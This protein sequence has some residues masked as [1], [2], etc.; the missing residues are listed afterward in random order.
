MLRSDFIL[1]LKQNWD[2]PNTHQ[3]ILKCIFFHMLKNLMPIK[4]I[5]MK[6]IV[7]NSL[8]KCIIP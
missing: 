3:D 4:Q 2:M 6:S 8:L 5:V 7:T 1:S